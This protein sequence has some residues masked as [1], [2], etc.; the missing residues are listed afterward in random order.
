M[1]K[2]VQEPHKVLR[3]KAEEVKKDEFGKKPLLN[4]VAKMKDSLAEEFDGVGLAAPQIGVSKRIF[5]VPGFAVKE[6]SD[7]V[8]INPKITKKSKDKKWMDEGCLSV[9][10]KYGKVERYTKVTLEA[11]DEYGNKFQ[12]GASGLLAHIFQ[13]ET[14]HLNGVLFVDKAKDVEEMD[15][16]QIEEYK[17]LHGVN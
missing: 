4:L 14:D 9:R 11:Y 5:I 15:E 8:C 7:L 1:T 16:K 12:R 6:D 17:K 10:W 3:E 2:I 13:H